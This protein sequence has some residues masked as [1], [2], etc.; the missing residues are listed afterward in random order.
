MVVTSPYVCRL[1]HHVTPEVCSVRICQSHPVK[2]Q[3][4]VHSS[5]TI[6][7]A[8]RWSGLGGQ[9]F[10]AREAPGVGVSWS[11]SCDWCTQLAWP[12]GLWPL[13]TRDFQKEA[14]EISA[15]SPG[16]RGASL[17][18]AAHEGVQAA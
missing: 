11:S 6:P 4:H 7:W 1:N 2:L 17:P 5:L 9:F 14:L 8:P 18:A 13:I 16:T 12:W 10:G 15:P 3:N